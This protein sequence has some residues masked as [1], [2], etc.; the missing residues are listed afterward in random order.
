MATATK[1]ARDY[2]A[3]PDLPSHLFYSRSPSCWRDSFGCAL[4]IVATIGSE[5][6]A[7]APDFEGDVA[8]L[9]IKNCIECH[10]ANESSG[11]LNLTSAAG[12]LKGGDSGQV[13][14]PAQLDQ[15]L[16]C[17][18]SQLAK[19][20]RKEWPA[21]TLSAQEQLVL[22]RWLTS[23]AK[24]PDARQLELYERTTSKRA[25]RDWWA[26]QPVHAPVAVH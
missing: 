19:C 16:L 15:S 21:S 9:L 13:I 26:L 25:G 3:V 12:M 6:G 24:W 2:N 17:G 5:L 14:N 10:S 20:H 11:G 18:A 4:A 23:G 7:Q 8:P 22:T 1:N